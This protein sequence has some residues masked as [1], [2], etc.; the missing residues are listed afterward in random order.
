MVHVWA[1]ILDKTNKQ[2][3]YI[4]AFFIIYFN[5]ISSQEINSTHLALL[6]TN[7]L[8]KKIKVVLM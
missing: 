4:R 7:T 6:S 2:K 8:N 1:H 3:M 5:D